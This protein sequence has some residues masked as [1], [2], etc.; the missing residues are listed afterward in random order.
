MT[1]NPDHY[2]CPDHHVDVTDQVTRKM[3]PDPDRPGSANVA[4]PG[5]RRRDQGPEQFKVIVTCPG[6]GE[7]HLLTCTGTRTP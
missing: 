1:L 2:E 7:P 3:N 4:F 6:A 5:L